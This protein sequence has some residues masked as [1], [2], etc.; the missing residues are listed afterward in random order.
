MSYQD[1]DEAA[2]ELETIEL[3]SRL[4][5]STAN[6]FGE[7]ESGQSNLGRETKTEVILRSRLLSALTQLNPD[8]TPDILTSAIETLSG[9]RSALS[10]VNANRDNY[11]LLKRV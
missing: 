9:D 1:P 4:G 6:C 8:L 11:K 7:W 3:F 10:L 2:L 5:Y